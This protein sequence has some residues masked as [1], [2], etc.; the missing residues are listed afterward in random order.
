MLIGKRI[1][2]RYKIL[3]LIGG[4]G[5]SHVY[6]AEDM[7]L[8]REVA[9]KVLRYDFSNEEEL[10]R[11]F[12]REALAATSLAH[13]N[14]VSIYDVGNDGDYHF[15]VMEYIKGKTLKQYIQ[16]FSPIAPAKAIRIMKQL[17]SAIEHAHDYQIVHRD[18]KPQNILV[19]QSGN[20]KI[21]DF[22]IATSLSAT[23]YTKT[24]SVI[25]TVHYLSPEQA[26]GGVASHKSDIY[27]LG[28]VLYELLTGEL[29]FSGESAVS[30][31]L[32]HLQSETPSVRAYNSSIPQS[33]ENVVLKATAKDP[34]HRYSD[35]SEMGEDIETAL[36]ASRLNE[37]KYTVPLDDDAT[38]VIP[39]IKEPT[40]PVEQKIVEP[41][42]ETPVPSTKK[43]KKSLK[44]FIIGGIVLLAVLAFVVYLLIKP[45]KIE[46][47]S[48]VDM[49]IE[50]AT[51]VLEEKG[52]VVGEVTERYDEEIEIGRVIESSPKEGLLRIKGAEID[53]VVSLGVESSTMVNYVGSQIEQ[54]Q[55][56]LDKLFKEIIIEKVY[57]N[58]PVG[59]IIEQT[60]PEGT[61]IIPEETTVTFKVSQG[62]K[63][64]QVSDLKNYTK[65]AIR[66]YEHRSGL[67]VKVVSEEFHDTVPE[68]SVISQKPEASKELAEGGTIE[69]VLSKGPKAKDVKTYMREIT[70]PYEPA[71]EGS[72]QVIKVYIE[73]EE[74]SLVDLF[75]EFKITSDKQYR[76]T[77]K[78]V[79]GK[80]A[81]YQILRDNIVILQETIPYN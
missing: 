20:V 69:V 1:N 52:F 25:G 35:V 61:E 75:E 73:D 81:A 49:T 47:P 9:I 8:N 50:E 7:I 5:M 55:S 44:P 3:E 57:S 74:H 60:P 70:I 13:P 45:S 6:L 41:K 54:V 30:I 56:M 46:V 42:A 53:L 11:R 72:E 19:D 23:S 78:I 27:A 64:V 80:K 32:K 76:I 14:I 4:G 34:R 63:M 36:L 39:I 65:E 2:E 48:V 71:L 43:K 33:L 38:K 37:P 15:I 21:T 24:N 22:G 58:L 68:G 77:L 29:P 79:E 18:I 31:A 28:I 66:D 51:E 12:Q 17:I 10:H 62:L 26:R 40:K 59:E 67:V 16:E